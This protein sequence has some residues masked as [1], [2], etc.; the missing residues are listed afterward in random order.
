MKMGSI[1]ILQSQMNPNLTFRSTP[2]FVGEEFC[3]LLCFR[4]AIYLRW[5]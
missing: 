3:K 1:Q 2:M 4:D 5:T